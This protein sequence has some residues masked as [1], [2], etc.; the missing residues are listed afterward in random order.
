MS[1][2]LAA[3]ARGPSDQTVEPRTNDPPQLDPGSPVELLSGVHGA[4]GQ[5]CLEEQRRE[6]RG[7]DRVLRRRLIERAQRTLRIVQLVARAREE[8][9]GLRAAPGRARGGEHALG[10][11]GGGRGV[12]GGEGLVR[13]LQ[14]GPEDRVGRGVPRGASDRAHPQSCA[15]RAIGRPMPGC[16][17]LPGDGLCDVGGQEFRPESRWLAVPCH[18]YASRGA[19][20]RLV[21]QTGTIVVGQTR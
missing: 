16:A 2:A 18:V 1:R 19:G 12:A 9:G 6:E 11:R 21:G 15:L 14:L 20:A 3:C 5:V 10:R 17:D 8:I 4:L 7:I 13:G